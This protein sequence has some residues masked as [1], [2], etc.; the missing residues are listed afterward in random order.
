MKAN[1]VAHKFRQAGKH[2]KKLLAVLV[3]P[4]KADPEYLDEV[5]KH[6]EQGADLFFVGGSLLTHGNISDTVLGL[7][8]RSAV[9]VVLFPGSPSQITENADAIL[10]LSL[11]SG[12]NPDTLIGQQIMAAPFLKRS[13]LEVISTA[14]LLIESGRQTT[15]SYI[16]NSTPIPAD[17][18][19]IAA[20]TA[21]AGELL[22]F[23]TIYMDAGSGAQNPISAK[24]I[25]KVK[26]SIDIPLIVGGGLNSLRK[27]EEAML[28]GADVLVIGSAVEANPAFIKDVSKLLEQYNK[29]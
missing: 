9:P 4:D 13:K 17:K 6:A 24:M 2:S 29:K 26:E 27:I 25:K 20:S 7:K 14:Y 1:S 15:A 18:P 8:R 23:S 5:C 16:S 22:G 3:D 19:G 11:L 28:A 12:R 10:F 21:I